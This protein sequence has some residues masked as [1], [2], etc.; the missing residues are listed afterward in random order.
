MTAQPVFRIASSRSLD[1]EVM[2][3]L[4]E[5]GGRVIGHLEDREGDHGKALHEARK[6]IKKLR[7]LLLLVRAAEQPLM[8][9]EGRR[10]R[11]AARLIA[12]P[13]EATAAV[14]TVDRFIAAFPE[15]VETCH[16]AEIRIKGL[17]RLQLLTVD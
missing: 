10:L 12:G 13:R 4:D 11:D 3:I 15:K 14:E 1:A 7:A 16:L 6:G 8:K 17:T 2:R 5:T 9:G